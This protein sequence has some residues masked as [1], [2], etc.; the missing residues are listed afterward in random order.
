MK[1]TAFN[2][3]WFNIWF[4]SINILKLTIERM[5]KDKNTISTIRLFNGDDIS[6]YISSV[7]DNLITMERKTTT[8]YAEWEVKLNIDFDKVDDANYYQLKKE[9]NILK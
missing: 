4:D 3:G 9:L 6:Q 1:L 2:N 8:V 5:I 7:S